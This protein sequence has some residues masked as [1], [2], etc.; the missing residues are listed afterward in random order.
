MFAALDWSADDDIPVPD[1]S[2][3]AE[4]RAF[5]AGL[6]I[7]TRRVSQGQLTVR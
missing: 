7:R 5:Y 6:A 3:A 4:L 1:G 2:S